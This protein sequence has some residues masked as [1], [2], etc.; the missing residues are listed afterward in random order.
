MP[1]RR[2]GHDAPYAPPRDAKAVGDFLRGH[3]ATRIHVA[4]LQDIWLGEFDHSVPLAFRISA[5]TDLVG[6]VLLMSY[7]TK[8]ACS[9]IEAIAIPMGHF[10]ALRRPQ[11]MEYGTDKRM[12]I[13]AAA[14]S[15][16]QAMVSVSFTLGLQ[17]PA[18]TKASP[19]V[20]AGNPA[21]QRSHTP[22]ARRLVARMTRHCAP[23][24]DFCYGLISHVALLQRGGQGVTEGCNRPSLPSCSMSRTP[25]NPLGITVLLARK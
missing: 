14:P 17:H 5:V 11:P 15:Q 7:P 22:K 24:F 4:D 8:V 19:A 2:A 25:C 10:M 21:V 6:L 16:V 20:A 9:I 23:F 3:S 1:P 12:D 13:K 18:L